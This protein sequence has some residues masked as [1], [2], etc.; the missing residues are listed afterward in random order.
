M[1]R[2]RQSDA[3]SGAIRNLKRG[4]IR[5][6]CRISNWKATD[7]RTEAKRGGCCTMG[8]LRP[9]DA[10]ALSTGGPISKGDKS[11]ATYHGSFVAPPERMGGQVMSPT[12]PLPPPKD[13]ESLNRLVDWVASVP[14]E[15]REDIRQVIG[16]LRGRSEFAALLHDQLF[17]LPCTDVGRHGEVPW[18]AA[19]KRR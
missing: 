1:S 14:R 7:R 12:L 15:R 13:V 19:E 5:G 3:F 4:K 18:E 8:L 9:D 17:A 2:L 6:V 10:G 16:S 11:M